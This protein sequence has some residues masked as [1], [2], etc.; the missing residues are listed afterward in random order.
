MGR[1]FGTMRG[2]TKRDSKKVQNEELCNLS[3]S[4]DIIVVVKARRRRR[5]WH[6]VMRNSWRILSGNLTR[7]GRL[8]DL[9]FADNLDRDGSLNVGF[10]AIQPLSQLPSREYFILFFYYQYH[11]HHHQPHQILMFCWNTSQYNLSNWST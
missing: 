3:A 11:Y 5:A 7:R 6:V 9:S 2:D 1:I 10:F 4:P 8:K